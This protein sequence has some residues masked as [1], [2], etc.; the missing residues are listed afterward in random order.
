[1]K[2]IFR[3]LIVIHLLYGMASTAMACD[4]AP[5][6]KDFFDTIAQHNARYPGTLTV[7]IGKV[8]SHFQGSTPPF[9]PGAQR[10]TAMKFAVTHVLQGNLPLGTITINGDNGMQCRP[11]VTNFPVGSIVAMG[12]QKDTEHPGEYFV[13]ICGF[14]TKKLLAEPPTEP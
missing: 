1:M 12:I 5:L 10:P 8:Q 13:S 2:S 7:V 14:Y 9:P 4:C 3:L 11:Y 6:G